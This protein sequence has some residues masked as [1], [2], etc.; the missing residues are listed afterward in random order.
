MDLANPIFKIGGVVNIIINLCGT[1]GETIWTM[2][3]TGNVDEGEM[4]GENR[5]NLVVNGS[6]RC[7]IQ[8]FKHSFNIM[9]VNLNNKIANTNKIKMEST[10]CAI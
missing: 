8:I 6:I 2:V 5:N 10:E 4:E 3:R 1:S 9:S 7:D